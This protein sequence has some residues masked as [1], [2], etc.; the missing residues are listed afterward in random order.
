MAL[1][2][3]LK[4]HRLHK[5]AVSFVFEQAKATHT[6][7]FTILARTA[8]EGGVSGLAIV[9]AK[10][11]V[12][13]AHQ[14]NICKRIARENFRLHHAQHP[15]MYVVAIAKPKAATATNEE[16]HACFEKFWTQP[17]KA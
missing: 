10:K 13:H 3:Y 14:R 4:R 11:K 1:L 16:L 12:K 9:V 8:P 6:P 7:C 5:K 15:A 17:K 2:S